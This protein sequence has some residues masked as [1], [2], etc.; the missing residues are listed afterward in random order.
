VEWGIT[1][2]TTL[3]MPGG[4]HAF[5]ALCEGVVTLTLPAAKAW[6]PRR[7]WMLSRPGEHAFA[8]SMSMQRDFF[9]EGR[10]SMAPSFQA[11]ADD[12]GTDC[13][14]ILLMALRLE[15]P[16]RPTWEPARAKGSEITSVGRA[17]SAPVQGRAGA[18]VSWA[19][20]FPALA[21][22]F[23][24]PFRAAGPGPR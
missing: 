14:S 21:S 18:W 9:L 12:L 10:E 23:R 17:L 16:R 2:R 6:V 22:R 20:S 15:H 19:G 8:A 24:W 13:V 4:C 11:T 3:R 5:A 7:N 1:D